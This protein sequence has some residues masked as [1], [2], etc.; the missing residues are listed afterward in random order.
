MNNQIHLSLK[1]KL[2][3]V[4]FLMGLSFAFHANASGEVSSSLVAQYDRACALKIADAAP[5]A[6][7]SGVNRCGRGV[8]YILNNAQIWKRK[9]AGINAAQDMGRAYAASGFKNMIKDYPTPEAAPAGA[10]LVYRGIYAG[11]MPCT[12]R[13]HKGSAGDAC[14]HT[15]VKGSDNGYYF[16]NGRKEFSRTQYAGSLR[17]QLI[18]VWLPTSAVNCDR[19]ILRVAKHS[20]KTKNALARKTASITV[21]QGARR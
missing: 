21:A 2:Q 8:T 4:S 7:R 9:A 14:G 19:A 12:R 6:R 10:I 17:R 5:E 1:S 3:T 13:P 15:E 20:T 11:K 16:G 18:G